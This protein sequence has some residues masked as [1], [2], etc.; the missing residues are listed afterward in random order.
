MAERRSKVEASPAHLP[1]KTSHVVTTQEP[2]LQPLSPSTIIAIEEAP[3]QFATPALVRADLRCSNI[4]SLRPLVFPIPP[5]IQRSIRNLHDIVRTLTALPVDD[6]VATLLGA[7]WVYEMG[8]QSE[9]ATV[10]SQNSRVLSSPSGGSNRTRRLDMQVREELECNLAQKI[11]T[12][13][14]CRESFLLRRQHL[15]AVRMLLDFL[16]GRPLSNIDDNDLGAILQLS[17]DSYS[18]FCLRSDGKSVSMAAIVGVFMNLP[19]DMPADEI[20]LH[21][22][23]TPKESPFSPDSSVCGADEVLRLAHDLGIFVVQTIGSP[24]GKIKVISLPLPPLETSHET[25]KA[26]QSDTAN[27]GAEYGAR[28]GMMHLP[29]WDPKRYYGPATAED[30]APYIWGKLTQVFGDSYIQGVVV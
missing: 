20:I 11:G 25:W 15:V 21:A 2:A 5:N 8:L 16:A 19:N 6:D 26:A 7:L 29:Y 30:F 12:N 9:T 23:S 27:T 1:A 24:S 3:P 14:F 17:K 10:S 13:V 28:W 22:L 4:L 18:I